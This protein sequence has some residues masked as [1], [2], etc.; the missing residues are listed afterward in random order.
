M[1]AHESM[2][3]WEYAG[4][5]LSPEARKGVEEHVATCT[6]CAATLETM[7]VSRSVLDYAELAPPPRVDGRRVDSAVKEAAARKL[8]QPRWSS[9]RLAFAGGAVA[10]CAAALVLFLRSPVP[11]SQP[12]VMVAEPAPPV[13]PPEPVA[14]PIPIPSPPRSTSRVEASRNAV[15]WT[16]GTAQRPLRVK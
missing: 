10:A 8:S 13:A 16:S 7:R 14:V 1:P 2:P 9:W 5:A 11:E 4:G 15:R 3:L 12:P 6:D